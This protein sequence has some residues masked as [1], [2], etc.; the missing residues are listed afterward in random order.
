VIKEGIKIDHKSKK[1]IFINY[2]EDEFGYHLW[3]NENK[4]IIHNKNVIFN[5]KEMYKDIYTRNL[6]NSGLVYVEVND[7]QVTPINYY[8]QYL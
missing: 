8:N 6:E 5:E 3:D 4:K 2:G 7:V 1:C